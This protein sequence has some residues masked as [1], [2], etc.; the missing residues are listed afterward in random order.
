MLP[1]SI[2]FLFSAIIQIIFVVW[3]FATLSQRVKGLE[4]NI[5]KLQMADDKAELKHETIAKIDAK[6]EFI[7]NH[8]IPKS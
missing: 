7:I 5:L 1:L 8:F 2:D 4:A 6:L 3:V